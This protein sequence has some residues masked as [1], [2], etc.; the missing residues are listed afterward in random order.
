MTTKRTFIALDISPAARQAC[1]RHVDRL[2]HEHKEVRVGWER[3]E[4]M[5]VTVKFLGDVGESLL[6]EVE[7]AITSVAANFAPLT[8]R[9]IGTGVFPSRSRPRILW[10]GVRDETGTIVSL[11]N[12]IDSASA[13]LGFSTESRPF[14]PHVTIGRIR[15]PHRAAALA[16]E[17]S[18]TIIEPVE[19]EICEV[20]IYESRLS[21]TGSSYSAVSRAKLGPSI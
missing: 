10:V 2:R 3:A 4:K 6:A 14:R 7:L 11:S 20:V 18:Q 1:E 5:H 13:A 9:L 8:C 21:P 16:E 19:F 12:E 17:H 15:E